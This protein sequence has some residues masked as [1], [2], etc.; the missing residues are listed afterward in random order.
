MIDYNKKTRIVFDASASVNVFDYVRGYIGRY[1]YISFLEEDM[2]EIFYKLFAE[3]NGLELES[4][5]YE[6]IGNRMMQAIH[7]EVTRRY[8]I[9]IDF[10]LS[11]VMT[12]ER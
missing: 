6:I 10:E 2:D 12:K 3:D 7:E 4:Y 5:S 1:P 11:K 9:K 8:S